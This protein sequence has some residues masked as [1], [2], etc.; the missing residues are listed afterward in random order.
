MSRCQPLQRRLS[1]YLT[2]DT[3]S[4]TSSIL[5]PL[6][7]FAYYRIVLS[8]KRRAEFLW[9]P[10]LSPLV[11]DFLYWRGP[12]G[13]LVWILGRLLYSC[14][15]SF[16]FP[17]RC[18]YYTTL[19]NMCITKKQHS[20]LTINILQVYNQPLYHTTPLPKSNANNEHGTQ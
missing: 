19:S 9:A 7:S 5:V 12:L 1:R 10:S 13:V 18:R 11:S 2:H 3:M 6:F 20:L 16:S 4:S 8:G 15:P 17:S 14:I